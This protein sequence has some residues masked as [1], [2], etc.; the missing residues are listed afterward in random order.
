MRSLVEGGWRAGGAERPPALRHAPASDDR[1]SF[2]ARPD[3]GRVPVLELSVRRR[4]F[5]VGRRRSGVG[6]GQ[7][8]V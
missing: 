8:G 3:P 7:F 6:G 5:G 2:S 1:G 4:S